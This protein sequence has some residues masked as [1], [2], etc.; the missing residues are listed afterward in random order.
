MINLSS[1]VT[2]TLLSITVV[3]L[4]LCGS[5]VYR[6]SPASHPDELLFQKA[7]CINVSTCHS[8]PSTTSTARTGMCDV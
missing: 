2:D 8:V 3:L 4:P 6:G 1:T 5:V 7:E